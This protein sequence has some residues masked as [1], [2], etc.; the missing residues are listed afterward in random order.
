MGVT[1]FKNKRRYLRE[2]IEFHYITGVGHF[3]LYD[4][5]SEDDPLDVLQYYIDQGI[6]TLKNG[7]RQRVLQM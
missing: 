3:I 5:G 1:M 7:P 4:N 2:W 6:V